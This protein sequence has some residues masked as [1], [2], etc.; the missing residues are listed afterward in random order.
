MNR[1]IVILY[2]GVEANPIAISRMLDCLNPY[3]SPNTK[4]TVKVLSEE[5]IAKLLIEGVLIN[6]AGKTSKAFT[7]DDNIK[8]AMIVINNR[9]ADCLV[10]KDKSVV[11]FAIA[12]ASAIAKARINNNDTE[13]LESVEMLISNEEAVK[14]MSSAWKNKYGF[15]VHVMAAI[16]QAYA[17]ILG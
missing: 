11:R 6:N 14:S 5:D 2:D 1:A 4:G 3:V 16:R 8:R 13:L 7:V 12:L 9:F 15:D 10:G 17:P